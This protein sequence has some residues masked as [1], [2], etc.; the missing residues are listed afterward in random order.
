MRDRTA[1]RDGAEGSARG[2]LTLTIG[3]DRVEKGRLLMAGLGEEIRGLWDTLSRI[4]AAPA[5]NGHLDLSGDSVFD[6]LNWLRR[7]LTSIRSLDL[8]V[9][10]N[11]DPQRYLDARAA[12]RRGMAVRGLTAPRNNAVHHPE[13]V[14]PGVDRAIGP[15]EDGCYLIFP[16]WVQRTSR[17][18]PM[19]TT[20]NGSFSTS[21]AQAYDSQVAGRSLPP[22]PATRRLRL[23]RLVG[24][25]PGAPRRR[26]AARTLPAAPATDRRIPSL[27]PAHALLAQ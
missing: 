24:T 26:R 5:P 19:F 11:S 2:G 18:D 10:D 23:L 13:V 27:V 6:V 17:L 3:A 15:L 1:G 21:Y 4:D 14:D 7:A 22:R 20:Q 9:F 12:D 25:E 8:E 16:V